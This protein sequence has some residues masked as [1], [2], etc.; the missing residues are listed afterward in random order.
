MVKKKK[1]WWLYVNNWS[2]EVLVPRICFQK[3]IFCG[4]IF[5]NLGLL[6]QHFYILT[7]WRNRIYLE[8]KLLSFTFRPQNCIR[9]TFVIV[10]IIKP[11][12]SVIYMLKWLKVSFARFLMIMEGTE[13]ADSCFLCRG[14]FCHLSKANIQRMI[15]NITSK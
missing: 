7:I 14:N 12:N 10:P 9:S 5:S 1:W 4:L 8:R 13:I 6:T 11:E 15:Q 2:V 3:Y